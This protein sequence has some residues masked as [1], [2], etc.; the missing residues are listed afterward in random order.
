[1]RRIFQ[2]MLATAA[3]AVAATCAFAAPATAC[4]AV[5]VGADASTDGTTIM[6]KSNDCQAVWG[7]YI[8][9]TEHVDNQPGRTMPVDNE[10]TVFAEL[11]ATTYRYTST[12]TMDGAV[13]D[14]DL[15]R[16][17]AVC[18]NEKGVSMLMSV[19]AFSNEQALAA[20]P[21]IEHGLTELTAVDLVTCQSA[22]AR[23][24]VEVLCGL[25]DRYGSSEVNIALIADQQEAWYVEMYGGHQYAAV[26][27]PA[28]M[29]A[30]FGNEFSLRYLKDYE[31]SIV[32]P[33]LD[34]LPTEKGYAVR[35]EAGNLDLLATYSGSSV[36]TDYSHR[37]TWIAHKILAPSAYGDYSEQDIYPLCFKADEKV[38]I[39]DVF[40]IMRN[41]FEGTEY[42]P[43]ETGRT[44]IRVIGTDTALSVHAVQTYPNL[45]ADISCVTW[46]CTGPCV[47]GAFVPVSNGALSV[48]E[49]YSR[50]QG[51]DQFG[52]FDTA[53]YPYYRIKALNTLCIEKD[54]YK[55]YGQP[56]REYWARA[57]KGMAAGMAEVLSRAAALGDTDA[58]RSY[59]TDY[60]NSM[61]EQVFNDAGQLL[62]DVMW[63]KSYNSN[64]LKN[65]LNPETGQVIDE[66]K[67]I[68]P[69]KVTL[70]ASAYDAVPD[71][72]KTASSSAAS[73]EAQTGGH[74][75][76][77]P[78]A[79]AV[80]AVVAVVAVAAFLVIRRRRKA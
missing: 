30:A 18:A 56:A 40:S 55:V 27:L 25:I 53:N 51:V 58:A 35:D 43:D 44:D 69:M 67:A 8:E 59:V 64:T 78:A 65:G 7:N 29:V 41:R 71:A 24:A 54:S 66:L 20:D 36:V 9:V 17:A 22:T 11:P 4:T 19:T 47:Y 5:Y 79:V 63:Y 50:N 32:S 21:L 10:N 49:A 73:G 46:E 62:N 74:A 33:A 45:P 42:S 37:R 28:N 75:T 61:Q 16:D 76:E 70:D 26:K 34:S 80:C 15:G 72:P 38:S 68:D 12:P 13:D 77:T 6:A 3:L 48:S 2:Q 52:V 60:C 39:E 57:E 14:S 1:M 23:E 31:D